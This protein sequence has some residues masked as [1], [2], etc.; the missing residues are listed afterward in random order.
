MELLGMPS[1][2]SIIENFKQIYFLWSKGKLPWVALPKQSKRIQG[3]AEVSEVR[4]LRIGWPLAVEGVVY[5]SATIADWLTESQGVFLIGWLSERGSFI[6]WLTL[7]SLDSGFEACE[8]NRFQSLMALISYY[9]WGTISHDL[10]ERNFLFS[11][12]KA[13]LLNIYAHTHTR[14]SMKSIL[15]TK[16]QVYNAVL[17]TISMVSFSKFL[18][19]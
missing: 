2:E 15:F 10:Q 13:K 9:G 1:H 19:L 5:W 3:L 6:D 16:F 7:R 11:S 4:M 8:W 14:I 17:L 12:Q 18:G